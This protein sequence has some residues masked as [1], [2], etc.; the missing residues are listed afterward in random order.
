MFESFDEHARRVMF[1]A[2]W[3]V[4]H[5]GVEFD[6]QRAFDE[7]Q[8]GAAAPTDKVA[9][10]IDDVHLLLGVL[11]GDAGALT[12]FADPAWPKERLR[13]RLRD[14]APP[15]SGVSPA[16]EIP[17][18][19][20]AKQTLLTVGARPRGKGRLIVP[21]HI[22]WAVLAKPS[23]PVAALLAEAGVTRDAI[24]AFLDRP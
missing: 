20:A 5:P 15:G 19:P 16:Q 2:R 24:E 21:E 22:V 6:M 10:A 11:Q 12:R 8:Q 13:E 1:F 4:M 18:S 17:F 3:S 9:A 23:T 7:V 14:L